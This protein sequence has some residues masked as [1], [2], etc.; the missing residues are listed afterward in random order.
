MACI[1]RR[2]LMFFYTSKAWKKVVLCH[3]YINAY[4]SSVFDLLLIHKVCYMAVKRALERF[5][6][7]IAFYLSA[8]Q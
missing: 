8:A 7:Q 2:C 6:K 1:F 5:S 3:P 4:I